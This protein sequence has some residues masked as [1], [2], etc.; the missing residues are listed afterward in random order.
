[1]VKLRYKGIL[2]FFLIIAINQL[3]SAQQSN[4]DPLNKTPTLIESS[5]LILVW[6]E[7]LSDGSGYKF[8]QKIYDYNDANPNPPNQ[9]LTGI[10]GDEQSAT[11]NSQVAVTAGDF[12][13]DGKTDFV[14]AYVNTQNKVRMVIPQIN[15]QNFGWSQVS[16]ILS[17]GT[18]NSTNEFF[19]RMRLVAGN[20]DSDPQ[21]E[22]ALAFIDNTNKVRIE[23]YDTDGTLSP[24][25]RGGIND[26]TS[27]STLTRF[28]ITTA[29]FNG[30]GKSEII[31]S[32]VDPSGGGTNSWGIFVKVYEVTG[33]GSFT[34][35]P[36]AKQ[37]IFSQPQFNISTLNLSLAAGDFNND[38]KTDLAFAFS[39]F[40]Q[41]LSENDSY[42]YLIEVS[43]NLNTITFN[44]TR[45]VTRNSV[46][47]NQMAK[48]DL[49]AG[50]LNG[51]GKDE[52]FWGIEG[53]VYVYEPDTSMVP[54]YRTEIGGLFTGDSDNQL[55]NNYLGIL[56]VDRDFKDDLV[57]AESFYFG[58]P[59][60]N[61]YFRLRVYGITGNNISS[62]FLKAQKTNEENIQIN[63]GTSEFRNY[64]LALGDF[65]GDRVRLGTPNRYQVT[66]I[67]QPMV[68]L[69]APPIHFDVINGI[70][71]DLNSCYN[72]N[73]CD[74][75]SQYQKVSS[76]S[77]EVKSEVNR[78]W[79]ISASLSGGGNILGLGVKASMTANYGEKFQ[80]VSNSS[81]T[82]TVGIQVTA[83][84]DDYI[85]A[86]V[87]DYDVW[88]Y[89]VYTDSGFQG[90]LLVLFPLLKE[91]RWFPAKSWSG[92]AYKPNHEVSNILSYYAYT[93]SLEQNEEMATRIKG[94]L[95][96]SFVLNGNSN[97]D[98]FQ[99]FTEFQQN[100]SLASR[101]VGLEVGASVSGW[102]IEV[103][104][105]GNYSQ[106][107]ISTHTTSV[108][109]QIS[110]KVHLDNINMGLGEVS[111]LVTPYSYWAK[112]GA[113][114]I[115]YAV[116]PE[117]S[118]PGGTQTWWQ[119][120]YQSKSD[121][122]FILPWR[123][124]PEKG[125]TLQDP[126]KRFQT[127]EITFQPLDS[128]PGDTVIVKARVH[129]YSLIPT[130]G[131]VKVKFYVG[132][133]DSGGTLIT[134][135]NG[136]SEFIT[137]GV[138]P[139]R[140]KQE[141]QM[142]WAIPSSL[143]LF[144]RIYAVIDPDNQIDELHT[145]NNKGWAILGKTVPTSVEDEQIY[146]VSDYELYQNYPNP[147]NPSTK[148]VYTIPTYGKVTIKVFDVLGREI[149][150][151]VNDIKSAG[152]HEIEF[153][154]AEL[155]LASGVY[156]YQMK[157]ADQTNFTK[158]FITTKK[159]LLIK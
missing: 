6:S 139:A 127:K 147:F 106:E 109:E 59:N 27:H 119:V 99:T 79:G 75:Y 78:D 57:T 104:V 146:T 157:V 46:G 66:N 124:D 151:L 49:V 48:N 142:Q 13:G 41:S 34:L 61:Q 91:N 2:L 82:V 17:Q 5:E 98:W 136:Q 108:T 111:Y 125:F 44:N 96:E 158:E 120:N 137:P 85:Y 51:D 69:N 154:T 135:L 131:A 133:P 76:Q 89:P 92:S 22:F 7:R 36:K 50:D 130:P 52:I 20:F 103:G 100:Q 32:G 77:V 12:N 65:N 153:N 159:M 150:T 112:N 55:T 63:G 19:R 62:L 97:I 105:S 8:G 80:R 148:I 38:I 114:V 28:N 116:R 156:F 101:R 70:I 31:I 10:R 117:I 90:N 110:L 15:P 39:F 126:N 24:V 71:Y 3:L 95:N 18:I 68:I 47:Q 43:E 35:V 155:G 37:V 122:A 83:T 9:L 81:Q 140:G 21:H 107:E 144:S 128:H 64:A 72:G 11:N 33:S 16:S 141:V 121:P 152:Q 143:P 132:D 4:S 14:S 74:F 129:N 73:N 58:D 23:I 53:N 60:S 138:I 84:E 56:D 26:E 102:G 86:T 29:D 134:A 94:S 54:V 145:N 113:L 115:D 93:D 88:E 67:L 40:T 149:S 30:D 123:Y 42:L 87:A 45:R 118:A 1:M 25:Y